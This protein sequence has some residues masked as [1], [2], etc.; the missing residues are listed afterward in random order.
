MA[1][2][3]PLINDG[4]NLREM[5][6]VE[7]SSEKTRCAELY[8]SDPSVTLSVVSSG[9]NLGTYY[10]TRLQAGSYST[11]ASSFPGEGTTAEPSTVSV[12]YSRLNQNLA[13][14][15]APADTSNKR[16]P[17]Y[18]DGSDIVSMTLTDMYDTF[19]KD[20]ITSVY[21][22]YYYIYNSSSLSGYT[23]VSGTAV[24]LDTGANTAAYSASSIP[25]T[26]DQP[27]TRETF[28]L[29]KKNNTVSSSSYIPV[30]N[31]SDNIQSYSNTEWQNIMKEVVRYAAVNL[32][33]YSIR[34]SIN[35]S[36]TSAGSMW[37]D[38]LNGSGN[39]QTYQAGGDDY[40]AQE[41]P[42]GSFVRVNTYTLKARLA[43]YL[44]TENL[45]MQDM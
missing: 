40:R 28:Y 12:T 1:V 35:G 21:T 3:R 44:K 33:G 17:V 45:H 27:Y 30:Y 13:S 5:T 6:D 11:N 19:I 26:L 18:Y 32:S 39:Y 29:F 36:G 9:G 4:N 20:A 23:Q 16:F 7:I 25:E 43:W 24:M 31:N 10:D 8:R 22:D 14:L 42:N 2:R 41:F 34:Y 38:K 37:D 15:T